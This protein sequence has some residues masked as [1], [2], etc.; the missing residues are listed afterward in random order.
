[1]TKFTLCADDFGLG[2]HT[3]DGIISL[4][5]KSRLNA[6]SCMSVGDTFESNAAR[7][8][9]AA[10]LAEFP[11]EIGLHLTFTEYAPLGEMPILA[12]TGVFPTISSLIL[13]A[14]LGKLNLVEIITQIEKQFSAF[15]TAFGVMPD[16]V[17]GHQHAHILPVVRDA[18]IPIAK[19][20]LEPNG[21]IR[22]CHLPFREI[23][24]ARVSTKRA[25]II[26]SL[27]K[28]LQSMLI[29]DKI[30]TNQIFYGVNEFHSQQDFSQMMCTWLGSIGRL[31]KKALI[32]CHPGMPTELTEASLPDTIA[33]R[34]PDE[35][36]YLSSDEFLQDM[37]HYELGL[38]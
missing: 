25:L 27:S 6:V 14:Y 13:K 10:K 22:S 1:M 36:A 28:R 11:V 32:M 21:W 16:F 35:F 17:D 31:N 19:T 38:G 24:Q 12:P 20:S 2:P 15:E 9:H 8:T 37:R 4:V 5:E 23:M 34:R 29:Q 26:S 30:N 7:L 18:L 3:D 33:N